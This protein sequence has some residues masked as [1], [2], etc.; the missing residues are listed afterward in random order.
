M[1]DYIDLL[2]AFDTEITR[3]DYIPDRDWLISASKNKSIKVWSMPREW[4]DAKQV[5]D[6]QK[7]ATKFVN[8]YNKSKLANAIA[9][10]ADDS[11]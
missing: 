1:L 4:R 9:K 8:D 7:Q 5:A 3:L 10:A 6:D 2:K 11:D